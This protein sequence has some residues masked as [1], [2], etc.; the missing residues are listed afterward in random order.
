[1]ALGDDPKKNYGGGLNPLNHL[2]RKKF[3]KRKKITFSSLIL[4]CLWTEMYFGGDRGWGRE[5]RREGRSGRGR[6]AG[7]GGG[8]GEYL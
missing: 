1:M 8:G 2:E 5:G 6:G 3:H 7:G 4:W